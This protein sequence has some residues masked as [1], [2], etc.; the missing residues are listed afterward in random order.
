[1]VVADEDERT[2]LVTVESDGSVDQLDRHLEFMME[3]SA[4]NIIINCYVGLNRQKYLSTST[5]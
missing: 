2:G 4:E 3:L 1:M 5:R